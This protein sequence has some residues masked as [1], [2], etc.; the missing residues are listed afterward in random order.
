M[1]RAC[2]DFMKQSY[3]M[4]KR[5]VSG[6]GKVSEA[7]LFFI[8]LTIVAAFFLMKR[9]PEEENAS[10]EADYVILRESLAGQERIPLEEYLIGAVAANVSEDAEPEMCKALAV[11]IRTNV[12]Y[13]GKQKGSRTLAYE[14]LG[15]EMLETE[16]Y[17]EKWG[18]TYEKQY[19]SLKEAVKNT[20]SQA[21]YYEGIPVELP[22]FPLS[23]GET[24]AGSELDGSGKYPYL[25]RVSCQEDVFAEKYRQE[26]LL[27]Q[28]ELEEK[29]QKIFETEKTVS[30]KELSFEKDQSAYVRN[31]RWNEKSVS[32][33]Y[34]RKEMHFDSACF[35]AEEHGNGL[36]VVTKGMGH[37]FGMSIHEANEMAKNGSNYREILRYFFP[38]CEIV[39]N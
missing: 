3:R 13:M 2:G 27:K 23:A 5:T 15:Q 19:E 4:K 24:R 10:K 21:L 31:V 6:R 11:L 18:K 39:K 29:L 20:E 34:F 25:Q 8:G 32:G 9:N 38:D 22:Y 12:I 35:S 17:Y 26:I 30:W 36:C 1:K 37:G 14:E 16:M 33:E 28:G 7:V